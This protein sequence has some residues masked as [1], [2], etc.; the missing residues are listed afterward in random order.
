MATRLKVG[1]DWYGKD[2]SALVK[3]ATSQ[4]VKRLAFTLEG[5]T[6]DRITSNGQVDTGFMRNSVYAITADGKS[7]GVE[8]AIFK[9]VKSKKTG[10]IGQARKRTSL[11][12]PELR[13]EYAAFVGVGADYA[14]H[15][16]MKNSFLRTSFDQVA[17]DAPSII[18]SEFGKV[19]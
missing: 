13:G 8:S 17:V 12:A 11:S 1:L 2:A 7:G 10:K 5:A 14:V 15:Q 18:A 19:M 3:R 4:S 9:G 6:K 16:E